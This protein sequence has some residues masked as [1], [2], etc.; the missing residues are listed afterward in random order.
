MNRWL[1]MCL[2]A[3]L[4]TALW[5]QG[6]PSPLLQLRTDDVD[7]AACRT[8]VDGKPPSTPPTATAL[9]SVLGLRDP[10]EV[11]MTGNREIGTVRQFVIVFA[12]PLTPGGLLVQGNAQCA[13][14]PGAETL[15]DDALAAKWVEWIIR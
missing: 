9:Y 12:R 1:G 15:P 5:G 7:V 4:G 2:L 10:G 13:Y 14:L 3:L 11:L 8:F 6:I